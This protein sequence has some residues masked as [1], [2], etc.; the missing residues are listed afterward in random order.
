MHLITNE[1]VHKPVD[2]WKLVFAY[3]RRYSIEQTFRYNKSEL[4]LESPRL[5]R[6]QNR[7][8][9]MAIVSLVYDFLLQTLRNWNAVAWIAINTWCPRTGK[10]LARAKAPLYR[11]RAAIHAILNESLALDNGPPT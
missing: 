3:M 7:L 5:W 1:T 2:A 11:L 8:K 4:A 6:W 10:K 9:I